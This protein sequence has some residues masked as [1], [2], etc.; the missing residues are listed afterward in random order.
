MKSEQCSIEVYH[1]PR[2]SRNAVGIHTSYGLGSSLNLFTYRIHD[3][4]RNE[5]RRE[6]HGGRRGRPQARQASGGRALEL[7]GMVRAAGI[8]GSALCAA[9]LLLRSTDRDSQV[10]CC[11]CLDVL[12][13]SSAVQVSAVVRSAY[14]LFATRR[15]LPI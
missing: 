11:R 12:I 10:V 13:G 9:Q 7:T 14:H 8:T 2:T 4:I 3:R 15:R 6:S 5:L 1:G